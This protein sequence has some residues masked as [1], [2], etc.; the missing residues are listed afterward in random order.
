MLMPPS[1]SSAQPWAVMLSFNGKTCFEPTRNGVLR[2]LNLEAHPS[3]FVTLCCAANT[4][5]GIMHFVVAGWDSQNNVIEQSP[6]LLHGLKL[7]MPEAGMIIPGRNRTLFLPQAAGACSASLQIWKAFCDANL[8]LV[9]RLQSNG[10]RSRP[11]RLMA[12]FWLVA[13]AAALD[14]SDLPLLRSSAVS[15]ET[16]ALRRA[17]SCRTLQQCLTV[18]SCWGTSGEV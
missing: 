1:T 2:Q 9:F 4:A 8:R 10:G 7:P 15:E 13:A 17:V 5:V 12:C 11:C 14:C 3:S 16:L 18:P 6:M